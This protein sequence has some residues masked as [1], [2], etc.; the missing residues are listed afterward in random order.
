MARR[1]L[2]RGATCAVA[3]A[4]A[5]GTSGPARAGE[6]SGAP[7]SSAAE[8][9]AAQWLEAAAGLEAAGELEAAASTYRLALRAANLAGDEARAGEAY[10]RMDAAARRAGVAPDAVV[11]R[12][13]VDLA[14][15]SGF[16]SDDPPQPVRASERPITIAGGTISLEAAGAYGATFMGPAFE[17]RLGILSQ[18][19]LRI[20]DAF[21]LFLPGGPLVGLRGSPV[22]G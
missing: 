9:S 16:T 22:Q 10:G 8:R 13:V 7:A 6:P 3:V 20:A 21:Y 15:T 2:S 17:M 14:D 11:E 1:F 18:L 5:L 19:E 12:A 4:C